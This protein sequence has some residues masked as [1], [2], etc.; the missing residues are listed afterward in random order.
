MSARVRASDTHRES[1]RIL[2]SMA[3][4]SGIDKNLGIQG[5][6]KVLRFMEIRD[7]LLND[8]IKRVLFPDTLKHTA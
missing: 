1:P 2:R 8:P 3:D 5:K 6:Q 7:Q 4:F